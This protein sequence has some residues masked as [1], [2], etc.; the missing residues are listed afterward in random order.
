MCKEICQ[1]NKNPLESDIWWDC[2]IHSDTFLIKI[3][4]KPLMFNVTENMLV[5]LN[6]SSKHRLP[7]QN[8]MRVQ[9]IFWK[10]FKERSAGHILLIHDYA[11]RANAK[12][13]T[14]WNYQFLAHGLWSSLIFGSW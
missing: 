5:S 3:S 12:R 1:Q 11:K 7:L 4:G 10:N 2:D 14:V 9:V 6:K 13:T 8:A